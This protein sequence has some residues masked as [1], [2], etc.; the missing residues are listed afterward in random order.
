MRWPNAALSKVQPRM[1]VSAHP[2]M[3]RSERLLILTPGVCLPGWSDSFLCVY[4]GA[5]DK[6]KIDDFEANV[7][8]RFCDSEMQHCPYASDN[9]LVCIRTHAH[10]YTYI[11]TPTHKYTVHTCIHA[12]KH[13]CI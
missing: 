5:F 4:V 6:A 13:T 11:H 1:M 7:G 12:Y 2:V 8:L 3:A 9:T 10:M